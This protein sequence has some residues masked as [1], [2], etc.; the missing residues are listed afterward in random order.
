M[1][2]DRFGVER[3]SLLLRV[4]IVVFVKSERRR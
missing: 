1:E 2:P 4:G 3:L